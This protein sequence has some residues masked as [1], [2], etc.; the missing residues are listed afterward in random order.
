M[1]RARLVLGLWRGRS[2]RGRRARGAKLQPRPPPQR[3]QQ[4]PQHAKRLQNPAQGRAISPSPPRE[5]TDPELAREA[6]AEAAGWERGFSKRE[7]RAFWFH[8]AT[9]EGVEFGEGG[10]HGPPRWG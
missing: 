7:Q 10:D 6:A 9:Q 1:L 4:Q 5:L 3:E 2:V 8:K